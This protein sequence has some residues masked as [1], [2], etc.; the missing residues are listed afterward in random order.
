[1]TQK[2]VLIMKWK[3]T[4]DC[5]NES[6]SPWR[7]QVCLLLKLLA[8]T[9]SFPSF[10]R[11]SLFVCDSLFFRSKFTFCLLFLFGLMLRTCAVHHHKNCWRR[12]RA[13]DPLPNR[14][15]GWMKRKRRRI[16]AMVSVFQNY[17][18]NKIHTRTHLQIGE[19]KWAQPFPL[20]SERGAREPSQVVP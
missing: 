8:L 11:A 9:K 1:M 15:L 4:H 7:V 18:K 19:R 2:M 5:Y 3:A 13:F 12:G 20:K 14:Q 6:E 17:Q 16:P 10:L